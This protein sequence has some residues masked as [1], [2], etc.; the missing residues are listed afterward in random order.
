LIV[1]TITRI[2]S[3]II[4]LFV[5]YTII[6]GKWLYVI[7]NIIFIQDYVFLLTIN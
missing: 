1:R 7:K 5:I 2:L 6:N 3:I 4:L